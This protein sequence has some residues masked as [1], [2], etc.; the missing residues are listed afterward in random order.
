MWNAIET[1]IQ[2]ATG[3][4]FSLQDRHSVSG[5]SINQAF[6]ISDGQQGYF[7]KLN[8]AN[9]VSMFEAEALGLQNLAASQSIRVPQVICWGLAE[10]NS[11]I[12]LEWIDLGRGTPPTWV[13]A[14]IFIGSL[15]LFFTCF[16][17]FA[18]VFPVIAMSEL[19]TIVKSSSEGGKKKAAKKST[20]EQHA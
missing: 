12:V 14:G 16:L 6:R 13:E 9:Q 20:Q 15:G 11:F 8:Q 17:L 5:G 7:L 19:K 18:R 1:Q 4:P 10:N 3:R 2:H